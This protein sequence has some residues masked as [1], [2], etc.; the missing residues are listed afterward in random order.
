ML[1]AL[2]AGH[3]LHFGQFIFLDE[4]TAF[5]FRWCS[6][7]GMLLLI[8]L[9]GR[10]YV[11]SSDFR[12]IFLYQVTHELRT[13]LNAVMLAGQL[14][15]REL[16]FKPDTRRI[17]ALTD[18]LL[19]AGNSADNILGNVLQLARNE[20]G[21]H[22]ESNACSVEVKPFFSKIAELH[23]V[24]AQYSGV[25]LNFNMEDMP[26]F[27]SADPS[28]LHIII[29]NLLSHAIQF[30]DRNTEVNILIRRTTGT[31]W[32]IRVSNAGQGIPEDQLENVF[33]P[34]VTTGNLQV[35]GTGLG[36]FIT[37][38]KTLSMGGRI[39][40]ESHPGERTTFIV[41]LPSLNLSRDQRPTWYLRYPPRPAC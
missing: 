34:F 1:V 38:A 18:H 31:R 11:R 2:E 14:I 35:E 20:S 28:K 30:A 22:D 15:K 23:G 33:E 26:P 4:Q 25:S 13:P 39:D 9:T 8:V 21:R 19:A 6:M 36:L 12:R 41:S 5:I 7:A 24:V 32:E 17:A 37:R 3:F 29:T 10:H 40:V 16:T 27:I